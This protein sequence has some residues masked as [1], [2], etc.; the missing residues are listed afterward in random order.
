MKENPDR[1]HD[2]TTSYFEGQVAVMEAQNSWV[3]KWQRI[4]TFVPGMYALDVSG[5]LPDD[6]IELCENY[7]YEIR[8]DIKTSS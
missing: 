6:M 1:V 4:A 5:K 7:G 3:A 8:S 2:C